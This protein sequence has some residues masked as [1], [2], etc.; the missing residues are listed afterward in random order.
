MCYA[1]PCQGLE[2]EKLGSGVVGIA[3]GVK[4]LLG[5]VIG[6]EWREGLRC[7]LKL[8]ASSCTEADSVRQ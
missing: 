4:D 2:E 6:R 5:H 8:V 3:V 7:D 1:L